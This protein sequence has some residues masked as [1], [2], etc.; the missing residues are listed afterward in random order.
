MS[1]RASSLLPPCS[2]SAGMF[3]SDPPP[4]TGPWCNPPTSGGGVDCFA[5][6]KAKAKASCSGS[7]AWCDAKA[8]AEASAKCGGEWR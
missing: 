5:E 7:D 3:H 1:L 4:C 2:P 8:S 6:A